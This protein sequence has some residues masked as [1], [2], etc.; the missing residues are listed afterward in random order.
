[1]PATDTGSETWSYAEDLADVLRRSHWTVDGPRKLPEIY[2]GMF[3]IQISR[4]AGAE[5]RKDVSAL[6][7]VLSRSGIKHHPQSTL[8]PDISQGEMAIFIGSESP[9]GIDASECVNVSINPNKM[10]E[11]PCAMVRVTES[12]CPIVKP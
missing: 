1:M 5:D 8:D 2:D 11:R 3:D 4:D 10:R 12:S 9:S 7:E 6:L